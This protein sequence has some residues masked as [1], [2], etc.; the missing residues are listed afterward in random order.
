MIATEMPALIF[1]DMRMPGMDG[2]A[3]AH[4]FRARYNHLAPIVVVTAAA[5]EG[6]ASALGAEGFIGKPFDLEDF[7]AA[8]ETV[9]GKKTGGVPAS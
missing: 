8:A 6:S 7:L 2:W 9:T 1:L 4:E 3:F 5:S